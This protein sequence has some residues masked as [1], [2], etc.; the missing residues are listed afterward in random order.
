MS[1]ASCAGHRMDVTLPP[2]HSGSRLDG[3]SSRFVWRGGSAAGQNRR[4]DGPVRVRKIEAEQPRDGRR[5]IDVTDGVQ[6]HARPDAPARG[7]E[8]GPELR[9]RV[10]VAV[11]AEA[12]LGRVADHLLAE[13][14]RE[15]VA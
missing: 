8:D 7:D 5:D 9:I 11:R 15:R 3:A 1:W 14:R 12:A 2:E 13:T 6:R 10:D 4:Q